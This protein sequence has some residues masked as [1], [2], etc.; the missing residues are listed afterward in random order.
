M[1]KIFNKYTIYNLVLYRFSDAYV[2]IVIY[3]NLIYLSRSKPLG[4]IF[5]YNRVKSAQKY[6]KLNLMA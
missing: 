5:L 3:Y 1:N 2:H 6:E 4:F